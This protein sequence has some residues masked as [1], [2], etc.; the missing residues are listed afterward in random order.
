MPTTDQE[1]WH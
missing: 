1:R